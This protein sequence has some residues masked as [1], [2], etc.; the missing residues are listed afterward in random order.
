M[1]QGGV[2]GRLAIPL[3]GFEANLFCGMGGGL[4]ETVAQALYHAHD[5][6]FAG[7]FENHF[8]HYFAFNT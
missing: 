5:A 7:S 6:K 8:E 4:V 1:H 3:G 2:V